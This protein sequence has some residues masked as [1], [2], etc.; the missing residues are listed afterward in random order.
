MGRSS[1]IVNEIRQDA[2]NAGTSYE[3]AENDGQ[4]RADLLS[5]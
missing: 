1:G 4:V 3:R 5:R 2:G